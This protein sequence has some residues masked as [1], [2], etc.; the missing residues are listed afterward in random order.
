MALL[1]VDDLDGR[2][3]GQYPDWN[4][5]LEAIAEMMVDAPELSERFCIVE[6]HAQDGSVLGFTS[7]LTTRSL[8]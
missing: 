1:L 2:I 7:S 3:V 6:F 8:T 4:S 5:G